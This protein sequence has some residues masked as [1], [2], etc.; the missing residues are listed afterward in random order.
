MKFIKSQ[1]FVEL[2]Y[3]LLNN[4]ISAQLKKNQFFLFV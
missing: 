1:S 3:I 2:P 4:V